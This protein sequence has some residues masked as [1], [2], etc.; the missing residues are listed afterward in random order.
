MFSYDSF[1]CFC[2]VIMD[3]M[4]S[5]EELF[6]T[7]NSFSEEILQDNYFSIDSI[8]DGL[9][10]CDEPASRNSCA[11]EL[12]QEETEE[13]IKDGRTDPWNYPEAVST[14]KDWKLN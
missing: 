13:S 5:D 9:E 3:G 4:G 1:V 11:E 6:H 10:A 12:K 7:Q 8:L 14:S 2:V